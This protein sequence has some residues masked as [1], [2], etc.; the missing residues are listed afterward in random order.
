VCAVSKALCLVSNGHYN[1][2]DNCS[3][4][5]EEKGRCT[6]WG[7]ASYL[8]KKETR[9]MGARLV[10]QEKGDTRYGGTS[11]ISRKRKRVL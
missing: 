5:D 8:K 9:V 10:S 1:E 4:S 11:R 2:S 7:C 3:V 6:L